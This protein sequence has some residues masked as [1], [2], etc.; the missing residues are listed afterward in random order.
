[1]SFP[2]FENERRVLVY[3]NSLPPNHPEEYHLNRIV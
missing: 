3:N 1:L 2:H